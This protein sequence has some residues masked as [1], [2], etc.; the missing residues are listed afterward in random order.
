LNLN[1]ISEPV[2]GELKEF[3]KQFSNVLKSKVALID[4]I[5]KYVLKQKGKKVRPLLVMLSAK[6]CGEI[7][8]RTYI[9]ANLV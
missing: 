9:A 8:N 2:T 5:T 1:K 6:L 4:L 3:E 7:N